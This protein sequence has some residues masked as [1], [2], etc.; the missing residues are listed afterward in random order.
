MCIGW[1]LVVKRRTDAINVILSNFNAPC[2]WST[3][4]HK[5]NERYALDMMAYSSMQLNE[6]FRKENIFIEKF[7]ETALRHWSF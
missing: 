7:I 6:Q 1:G 5:E 2:K 4:F 3:S